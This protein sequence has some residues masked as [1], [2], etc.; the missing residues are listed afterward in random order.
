MRTNLKSALAYIKLWNL[1]E[2]FAI[3]VEKENYFCNTLVDRIVSWYPKGEE[4]KERFTKLIGKDDELMS[5][6]E[7]FGP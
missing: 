2:E 7:P 3:W 1:P 5:V 4:T 6:G